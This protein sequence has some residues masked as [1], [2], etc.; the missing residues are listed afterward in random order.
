MRNHLSATTATAGTSPPWESTPTGLHSEWR[1]PSDFRSVA[2]MRW[3]LRAFLG[4]TW[5]LS[6]EE[7]D[8]LVLAT[9]EAANNAVEH[10]QQSREPFFHV[11]TEIDAATV[12]I[13]VQDYGQWRQPPAPGDRGRG[14]QL[15]RALAE[16]TVTGDTHGTT[17]TIR[18]RPEYLEA[19]SE[20]DGRAS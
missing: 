7:L 18:R 10:A 11:S 4:Q 2:E 16:T 14:L 1:L 5:G 8:D 9:C 12:T 6:V 19:L 13:V 3:W 20:D 15:M 17:V